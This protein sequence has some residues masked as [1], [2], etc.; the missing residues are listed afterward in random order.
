TCLLAGLVSILGRRSADIARQVT[1]R[2]AEL[3]ESRRL[4]DSLLHALPGMAYRCLYDQQLKVIYV[5]DG[6]AKLTGYP[7]DDFVWGKVHFRQLIHPED[8]DRVRAATQNALQEHRAIEVEYRLVQRD[9]TEKWV[10]SRGR[11]VY[12][13]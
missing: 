2:T 13:D 3:N 1:E 8:V 10:L 11:G 6:A 12:D 9:G 5:S 7:P 4:L